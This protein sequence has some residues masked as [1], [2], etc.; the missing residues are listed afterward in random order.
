MKINI[1]QVLPEGLALEEEVNP[2]TLDLD[3]D[4]VRFH[5][6]I[7]V[8]AE[9]YKIADTVTVELLLDASMCM[10]CSRCLNEFE[11]DFIKRMQLN[12]PV[13]E[14][15]PLIDLGPD[16]REEIILNYP[17]KPLCNSNCKGLCPQC[18]ENL[19]EGGCSCGTTEKKTF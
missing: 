2:A 15:E 19:N 7:K 4:I 18:G 3:T 8:K 13:N 1:N 9:V 10:I 16:I 12:Y 17:I 14:L 5:R 6:P 11:A